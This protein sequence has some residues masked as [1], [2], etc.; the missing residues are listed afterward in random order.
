MRSFKLDLKPSLLSL[1][2]ELCDLCEFQ[3]SFASQPCR[4]A[5]ALSLMQM[6]LLG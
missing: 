6:G 4:I 2:D 5:S 1:K 3:S